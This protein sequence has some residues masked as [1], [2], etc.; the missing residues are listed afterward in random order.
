MNSLGILDII[1][2]Y[3]SAFIILLLLILIFIFKVTRENKKGEKEQTAVQKISEAKIM[4]PVTNNPERSVT[5]ERMLP[6]SE[7]D[8]NNSKPNSIIKN[9]EQLSPL[10]R[11]IV[12]AEIL[13]R[14]G[15][16]R[17]RNT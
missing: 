13:G 1:A 7:I 10:K 12:W 16:R 17:H 3:G 15:G 5:P 2:V 6:S 8:T 14:P 9:L 11:G 4:K